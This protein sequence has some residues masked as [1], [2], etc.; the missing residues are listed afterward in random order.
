LG[1][2]GSVLECRPAPTRSY[3]SLRAAVYQRVAPDSPFDLQAMPKQALDGYQVLFTRATDG[4]RE[5]GGFGDPEQWRFDWELSYTRGER[6][7]RLPTRRPH[8]APVGQ[9]GG[10]A[11][12][13]RAAIDAMAASRCDTRRLLSSLREPA[14]PEL[15]SSR[16][17]WR[18]V[19]RKF[20]ERRQDEVRR[21][22]LLPA[23]M[24]GS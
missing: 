14:P 6:I 8:P 12:G 4:M 18:P 9:A 16:S 7:D 3:R 23:S 5:A 11:G 13:R 21:T 24:R 17:S 1:P 22:L 2:A 20:V 10:G 15:A 19:H